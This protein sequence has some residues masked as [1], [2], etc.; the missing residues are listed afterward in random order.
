GEFGLRRHQLGGDLKSIDEFHTLDDL[1]QLVMA[2]EP[3]PAFLSA[4]D[5]LEDHGER[6]L[7]REAALR[8][9]RPM[10]DRREGALDR[11][12][13]PQVLP[14]LDREVVI[15]QQRIAILLQAVGGPLVFELISLDE[16]VE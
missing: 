9:D 6:G 3:A 13:G 15:G 14:M 11:V 16:R 10:A 1:W 5:Q 4:L 12:R 2:V 8:A 7:V